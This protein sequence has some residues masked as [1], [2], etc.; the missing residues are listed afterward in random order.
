MR[1]SLPLIGLLLSLLVIPACGEDPLANLGTPSATDT[2]LLVILTNATTKAKVGGATVQAQGKICT[3]E[4]IGGSCLIG[5]VPMMR[6]GL[7]R[8]IVEAGTRTVHNDI[9]VA[10]TNSGSDAKFGRASL[11]ACGEGAIA[12]TL[13]G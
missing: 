6:W 7:A 11:V 13:P 4:F 5:Q 12:H 1:R 9:R 2:G 3:T 8:E 10:D